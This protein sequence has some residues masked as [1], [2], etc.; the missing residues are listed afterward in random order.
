M[1]KFSV[2]LDDFKKTCK[3]KKCIKVYNALSCAPL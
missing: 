2:Y 3:N 1:V